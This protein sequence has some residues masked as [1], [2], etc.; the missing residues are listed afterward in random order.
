MSHDFAHADPAGFGQPFEPS[1]NVDA[2]AI[3][4]VAVHDDVAEVDADAE[5]DAMVRWHVHIA[6]LHRALDL[7]RALDSSDH[8][9]EFDQEAIASCLDDAALVLGDLRVDQLSPMR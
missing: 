5:R 7:D 1:R 4:I 6:V 8:A 9:R 3:N 2:I